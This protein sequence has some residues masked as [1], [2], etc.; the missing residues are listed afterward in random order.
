LAVVT[1]RRRSRL[2]LLPFLTG[3]R[4][5]FFFSLLGS[6]L[7]P[8]TPFFFPPLPFNAQATRRWIGKPSGLKLTPLPKRCSAGSPFFLCSTQSPP[9]FTWARSHARLHLQS[10]R[11]ARDDD[12]SFFLFDSSPIPTFSPIDVETFFSRTFS[13][14]YGMSSR[15]GDY[16][17]SSPLSPERDASF[18]FR[19][20]SLSL[21]LPRR[22]RS[23]P[24]GRVHP[25]EPNKASRPLFF[26]SPTGALSFFPDCRQNFRQHRKEVFSRSFRPRELCLSF[27]SSFPPLPFP[28]GR[29]EMNRRS[30]LVERCSLSAAA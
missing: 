3:C 28:L 29:G 5:A 14:D 12:F 4:S 25:L 9:P 2:S 7:F 18:F 17:I 13:K 23:S 30:G 16:A 26:F 27:P 20:G 24:F 1:S 11:V 10:Q 19:T 8:P 22:R 15:V 6:S 21:F